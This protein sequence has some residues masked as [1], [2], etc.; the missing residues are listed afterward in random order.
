[1]RFDSEKVNYLA[2]ILFLKFGGSS[3]RN[4]IRFESD[5][6]R[7]RA[8]ESESHEHNFAGIV[9]ALISSIAMQYIVTEKNVLC[10]WSKM[11]H[12]N[13]KLFVSM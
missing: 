13:E 3:D 7:Q 5:S 8:K 11:F 12:E 10:F 6:F 9:P 2:E 4:P 1:V